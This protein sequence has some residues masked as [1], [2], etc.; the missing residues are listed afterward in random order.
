[1]TFNG[2]EF[3]SG[4]TSEAE[5]LVCA[6]GSYCE[7]GS[8]APKLCPAGTYGN[9][10]RLGACISCQ[11]GTFQTQVNQTAC[12]SCEAGAY[13]EEGAAAP[14][15]CPA[16]KFGA[17]HEAKNSSYCESC[18]IGF[19]CP[20]GSSEPQ[21]CPQGYKGTQPNLAY[22]E[23]CAM[24]PKPPGSDGKTTSFPGSSSCG[25]CEMGY[26]NDSASDVSQISCVSCE[27]RLGQGARCE[28]S[29]ER[30]ASTPST[31]HTSATLSH[32]PVSLGSV[33][34]L[35][36]YW[37]L[38]GTSTTLYPCVTVNG[39]S[40][41]V[42]GTSAGDENEFKPLY[43]GSGYCEAG[44]SGPL[45]SLCMK[46][47][48]Y[49]EKEL[50]RCS[51]CPALSKRVQLPLAVAGVLLALLLVLKVLRASRCKWC[52]APMAAAARL[53]S[54]L[55][56]VDIVPRFK[57]LLTF[58]QLASQITTTYNV[59]VTGQ[60]AQW[61][62]DSVSIFNWASLNL[63]DYIFPGQCIESGFKLRLLL[64][65]TWPLVVLVAIPLCATI[66]FYC[67]RSTRNRWFSNVLLVAL[68]FDLSISFVL[69]PTVSKGI[70]SS[71]NC[72]E[73]QIAGDDTRTFLAEDLLIVCRASTLSGG[74]DYPDEY[75]EIRRIAGVFVL[76]WP[77]GMPL[78]F[79][80]VLLPLRKE[81]L[82]KR[83]TRM[84]KATAFLHKEYA[85]A[86]FWWE[87][88]SLCQRLT[89]SGFVLLIPIENDLWRIFLGILV[90]I[91]YLTLLQFSQP[92]A[93]KDI[94][95]QATAAQF[96]LVCV[97]LGAAARLQPLHIKHR[98]CCS[99]PHLAQAARSSSSSRAAARVP[100]AAAPPA[101]VGRATVMATC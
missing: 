59:K 64:R 62:Q 85:P 96:S 98:A 24:C 16:G 9:A 88:V 47:D 36:G 41:C 70:F 32:G 17:K 79:L 77:I 23:A 67:R 6:I 43:T 38:S 50:A 13:C 94:N 71:F 99:R 44:Y 80:M 56:E 61:Y 2:Q 52:R 14:T 75:S 72:V 35:P 82:L 91:G 31:Y 55:R 93:R 49:Y 37:R 8:A 10:P 84:V 60:A 87:V 69:C 34:L 30:G 63:D 40:S 58:F 89:L 95:T 7:E 65:G 48:T 15:S 73:Y 25:F 83:K 29:T 42:G 92:Y 101:M 46:A 39:S 51:K 90:T 53:V 78:V 27:S 5:C 54:Q 100:H 57:L 81:L 11:A 26:F 28:M 68:P 4:G 12:I 22:Q 21:E 45:C 86:Y 18:P 76:L 33:E 3:L 19:F 66:F 74:A 1:M 20:S 97:F